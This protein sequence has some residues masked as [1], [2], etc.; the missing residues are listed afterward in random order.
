MTVRSS[1]VVPEQ[2]SV[3]RQCH[4]TCLT[5]SAHQGGNHVNR[6]SHSNMDHNKNFNNNFN[7]RSATNNGNVDYEKD[8]DGDWQSLMLM[9]LSAI[10]INPAVHLV[11]LDPFAAP[12]PKIA[13]VPPTPDTSLKSCDN[14]EF[15]YKEN[16]CK[17]QNNNPGKPR[18][19]V[20]VLSCLTE[21]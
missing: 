12:V 19:L 14:N 3:C 9:G 16:S 17:C 10:N 15:D 21:I 6:H 4:K 13:V 20:C 2:V 5:N 8:D 11:K 18:S 1:P 7:D